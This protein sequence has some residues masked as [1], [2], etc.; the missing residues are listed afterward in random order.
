MKWPETLTLVRHDV[1]AFNDANRR[2]EAD[3]VF[4][5][6]KQ[7]FAQDHTSTRTKSLAAYIRANYALGYGDH[8]TPL[9][10]IPEG[11]TSRSEIMASALKKLMPL[12]DVVFVSPYLRTK[13]TLERMKSGWP[14]LQDVTT[15]EEYRIAEQDHGLAQLYGDWRV[16]ET[17]NPE[18]HLLYNLL[19]EYWYRYPQGES[20]PDVQERLRSWVTTLTREFHGLV[21]LAVLHHL[22]ILALRANLE[23][24]KDKDFIQV[25]HAEKPDN[26]SVTIYHG[27]ADHKNS[28]RLVLN[29]YNLKLF[30]D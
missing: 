7:A 12:P 13:Q 21:V 15:I 10:A 20:V 2:K 6:F 25:N 16:F 18:Q 11:K 1:S 22:S 17:F 9:A 29:Q 5:D 24:W 27:Q 28:G 4:Q 19:G 30:E 3:P 14:Q 23:R 8:N 26:A